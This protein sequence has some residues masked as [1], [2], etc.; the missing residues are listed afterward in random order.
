MTRLVSYLKLKH[1]EHRLEVDL[2]VIR[3]IPRCCARRSF[4]VTATLARPVQ[5]G[6]KTRIINV[7]PGDTTDRNYAI[8]MDIGTTTIYGQLLDLKT[9]RGSGR[10]WR[11]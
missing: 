9:G 5:E 8:A 3:K 1:D 7:Q 2:S 6:S 11:F 4:K 10:I